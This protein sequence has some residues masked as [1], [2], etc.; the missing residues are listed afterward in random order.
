ML[1]NLLE[2]TFLKRKKKITYFTDVFPI[3]R[4]SIPRLYLYKIIINENNNANKI[5]GKLAYRFHKVFGGTWIN[6]WDNIISNKLVDKNDIY[7]LLKKLSDEQDLFSN[8]I[9]IKYVENWIPSPQIIADFTARGMST[10]SEIR[11]SI[12]SILSKY[13]IMIDNVFLEK[14]YKVKSIVLNNEAAIYFPITTRIVLNKDLKQYLDTINDFNQII[15]LSVID[16][17]TSLNG[18]IVSIV[19]KVGENNHR[20]RLL[21]LSYNDTN[22]EKISCA[23]DEELIVKVRKG[24]ST[25]DYIVSSLRILIGKKDFNLFNINIKKLKKHIQTSYKKHIQIIHDLASIFKERNLIKKHPYNSRKYKHLFIN[26]QDYKLHLLL[27]NNTKIKFNRNTIFNNVKKFGLY[28]IND[29]HNSNHTIKVAIINSRNSSIKNHLIKIKKEL[30]ILGLN[31]VSVG[32]TKI[33]NI[34]KENFD[35]AFYKLKKQKPNIILIF[36]PKDSLLHNNT[37]FQN[38]SI[39]HQIIYPKDFSNKNKFSSIMLKILKKTGNIPFVLSEKINYADYLIKMDIIKTKS[40]NS[41]NQIYSISLLIYD[42]K[43][44]FIRSV[45]KQF[46]VNKDMSFPKYI[47]KTLF[48]LKDFKNKTLIIIKNGYFSSIDKRMINF[49]LSYI[50]AKFNFIEVFNNEN[51]NMYKKISKKYKQPELASIIRLNKYEAL[52]TISQNKYKKYLSK[53]VKIKTSYPFS[54]EQAIKPVL[55]MFIF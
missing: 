34:K 43:G 21:K 24:T 27:G 30:K 1:A 19:G 35:L 46:K 12:L 39:N 44:N 51:P 41:E 28:K 18:E 48:P 26:N 38:Y 50:R 47:L 15:G 6:T 55:G 11:K 52:M 49:W 10:D 20:E 17:N 42:S 3:N 45:N 40:I 9:D 31:I 53:T 7:K 16:K 54:I 14:N 37:F 2:K 32:S 22:K 4:E 33:N 13:T 25:Y 5:C 23:N 36:L 29:K 8:I